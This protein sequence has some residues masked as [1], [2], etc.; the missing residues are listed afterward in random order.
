MKTTLTALATVT[1]L[2]VSANAAII[3]EDFE[4][5]TTPALPT[6]WQA[7][8]SG[9]TTAANG[10]PGN[11][12]QVAAGNGYLVNSGVAFDATQAISGTF[13][14]YVVESGHY[15]NAAFFIGDV[16]D[17]L[18]STAGDHLRIDLRERSFGARANI[19]DADGTTLFD[20]SGDN[21]YAIATDE[22]YSAEFSW[23]P[24]TGT[25]S[26][27][28]SGPTWSDRGPMTVTS[29]SFNSSDVFF[30]FGTVDDPGRFDNISLTGEAIPEPASLALLG[31]AG[32]FLARR[33]R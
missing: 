21:T 16:Q 24:A 7:V 31:L 29:Y 22:W 30:G 8:G 5:V 26:F 11:N 19:L 32:A 2:A 1:F 33:R 12:L 20:G 10:N 18:G 28:W 6:G 14:F 3:T 9:V 4:S 17:G 15:S 13:D 27:S 23:T 25:F